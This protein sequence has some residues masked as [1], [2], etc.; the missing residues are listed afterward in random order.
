MSIVIRPYL[1]GRDDALWLDVA[2]RA[3]DEDPEYTPDTLSDFELQKKGPWF[4][5]TGMMF[6]ELDGKVAGCADASID[7]CAEVPYGT[8][9]GPLVLPQCRRRGVGHYAGPG[10]LREPQAAR[11]AT[12]SGLAQ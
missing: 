3:L 2:N 1:P 12:G 7:R 8:L 10:S 6:A 9:G 5:A 11:Q 4:D